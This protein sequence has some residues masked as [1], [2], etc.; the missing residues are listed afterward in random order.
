MKWMD[1]WNSKCVSWHTYVIVYKW[2]WENCSTSFPTPAQSSQI[3]TKLGSCWDPP[4]WICERGLI[5]SAKVEG[6]NPETAIFLFQLLELLS[7][8]LRCFHLTCEDVQLFHVP[9]TL[10]LH[11]LSLPLLFGSYVGLP[12]LVKHPVLLLLCPQQLLSHLHQSSLFNVQ[13][14][15]PAST[16]GYLQ[17]S[18]VLPENS[19]RDYSKRVETFTVY[20]HS[21]LKFSQRNQILNYKILNIKA[22]DPVKCVTQTRECFLRFST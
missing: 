16:L 13:L 11:P 5:S 22:L 19:C 8:L 14:L 9:L 20:I 6:A 21:L 12:H 4:E 1:H 2:L 3:I 18:T 7:L 15:L 10:L 17:L